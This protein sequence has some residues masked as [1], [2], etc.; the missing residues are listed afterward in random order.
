MSVTA[1]I[2]P[3]VPGGRA[4][5][6]RPRRHL[7]LVPPLPPEPEAAPPAAD[8]RPAPLLAPVVPPGTPWQQALP[9][10]AR[11]PAWQ[12]AV[13]PAWLV[14]AL[15][16]LVASR[17]PAVV[18]TCLVLGA[19]TLALSAVA[20]GRDLADLWALG[21]ATGW[22]RAARM[23]RHLVTLGPWGYLGVRGKRTGDWW[24]FAAATVVWMLIG[25]TTGSALLTA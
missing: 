18:V 2:L 12:L 21:V 24:P 25:L 8:V 10:Y 4:F 22:R 11:E 6:D 7:S 15:P 19:L 1:E 9:A 17:A 23:L 16:V 13:A 20:V 14:L 3:P 5:A